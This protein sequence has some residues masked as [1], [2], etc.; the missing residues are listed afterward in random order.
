MSKKTLL[1]GLAP[2]L[3]L[4][5]GARA[6]TYNIAF[7]VGGNSTDF[8]S[9]SKGFLIVDPARD[10]FDFIT[11]NTTLTGKSDSKANDKWG[12]DDIVIFAGLLTEEFSDQVRGFNKPPAEISTDQWKE[13]DKLALV[14]FPSGASTP[15]S[16][17][18][19]YTSDKVDHPSGTIPFEVSK[20][21][22][23]DSI[24]AL[25]VKPTSGKIGST[26][27]PSAPGGGGGGGGGSSQ[28]QKSKKGKGKSSSANKSSGGSKKSS[29]KK[30]S[31]GSSK[32]SKG[33]K[34][35]GKKK[36]GGKKK[37]KK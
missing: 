35:S 25:G 28:V 15:G 10:G 17:Y 27:N 34:S 7:S 3:F 33:S 20:N 30:S 36:S 16:D 5:L 37:S 24:I 21:G 4:A 23:T 29:A 26:S 6:A 32:E 2:I 1:L 14:W 18:S 19:Y 11:S 22:S 8:P 13:G 31:G 12:D 9:A